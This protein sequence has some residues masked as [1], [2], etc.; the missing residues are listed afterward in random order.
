MT[1]SRPASVADLAG[2]MV[3]AATTAGAASTA[4]RGADWRLGV[5][6]AVRADGTIDVGEIRARRIGSAYPNPTVGDTAVITQNSAGNW[7]ALGATAEDSGGWTN[8]TLNSTYIN[9]GHGYSASWSREGKRVWLRGHIGRT[10]G[11][12][13][14]AATIATIP[15][16]I[17]PAGGTHWSWAAARDSNVYPAVIRLEITD[18][19]ALRTYQT[20]NLPEWVSLDGC[21][22]TTD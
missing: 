12:I 17:R 3:A 16:A 18:V 13:A 5:V 21:T 22:Y 10:S 9:P 8:L 14:N 15:S 19:G 2:A 6:T 4:V 11:T 1:S 7:L 20:S